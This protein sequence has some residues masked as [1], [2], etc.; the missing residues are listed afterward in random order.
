MLSKSHALH[1]V[2]TRP[3]K[4]FYIF[5]VKIKPEVGK[6]G[7]HYSN[8]PFFNYLINTHVFSYVQ[9]HTGSYIKVY[10]NFTSGLLSRWKKLLLFLSMV[11]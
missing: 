9:K 4:M 11:I 8:K 1:I 6:R 7:K 3:L 5:A 2:F 10:I